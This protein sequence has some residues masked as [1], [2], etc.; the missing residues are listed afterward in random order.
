MFSMLV[1]PLNFAWTLDPKRF[2][3]PFYSY[4]RYLMW[5]PLVEVLTHSGTAE[6]P[7]LREQNPSAEGG[8]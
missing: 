7:G 2:G 4:Y 1:A 3:I 8:I 5:Q 6:P